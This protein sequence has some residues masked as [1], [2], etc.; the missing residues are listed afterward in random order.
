[1][2]KKKET[3]LSCPFCGGT[4]VDI[5]R[6]NEMACWVECANGRCGAQTISR[7]RRFDAVKMWN[8]RSDNEGL[9]PRTASIKYDNDKG[10]Q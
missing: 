2:A 9:T 7:I 4:E 10:H 5:N 3:I 8:R 6:T 1:M